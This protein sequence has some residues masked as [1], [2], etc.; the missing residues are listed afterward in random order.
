M[1]LRKKILQGFLFLA[2]AVALCLQYT[3]IPHTLLVQ[4]DEKENIKWIDFDVTYTALKDAMNLDIDTYGSEKHIDWVDSLAYLAATYGGK[5]SSYKKTDLTKLEKAVAD[6]K[7]IDDIAADLKYF[8]YYQEAYG[9]VLSGFLGEFTENGEQK[10]GLKAFS[11]IAAGYYYSDFDDFGSSR[12]YG[13]SRKHFGHDLMISVGTPVIA[14]ES[15]IVEATGWNQYGGWRIGIRSFDGKRYY[16]YAHLRKDH[17]YNDRIYPGMTVT[18]GDVIGYTGQTGYSKKEN[19]NNID[20]PHLHYGMQIIF[21]EKEKDSPNQIW[22]DLYAITKLLSEHRSPVYKPDGSK[23]YYRA[24]FF[25]EKNYYLEEMKKEEAEKLSEY[26]KLKINT[27]VSEP[28]ESVNVSTTTP[29]S[30]VIFF[31]SDSIALPIV[32]YHGLVKEKKWQNQ[33]FIDPAIF[34]RDL[35]Y[36]QKNGYETIVVQD[37]IDYTYGKQE[38]PPKPIMITF[39]DGY[40]NNCLYAYPLL[41]EYGMKAVFAPVGKFVDDFSKISNHSEYYAHMTWSDISKMAASG[42]IEIQN[43]S[44]DLHYLNSRKGAMQK[45][46]ESDEKY[47]ALLTEDL[48]LSQK[49]MKKAIGKFPTAFIYPYGVYNNT[50]L[51]VAKEMGFTAT[52]TCDQK[53]NYITKDP[54]SLYN[55]GRYIRTPQQ[56]SQKFFTEIEKKMRK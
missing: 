24:N 48:T 19:V 34:E 1:R 56:S 25:T 28:R 8:P 42:T 40:Y 30:D 10:Y 53:I 11:P 4:S 29:E 21:D 50:T 47:T 36:L 46:G 15:G 52:F 14:V 45:R 39:D 49:K 17:P 16:Y 44:Y 35:A 23:E 18:A 54:D 38:L 27:V 51:E 26:Y 5:F 7:E 22:I 37:L 33:Y 9:A 55:L 32:M 13:Y 31:K 20:T 41:R 2:V 12:S 43:H 6:G 3:G